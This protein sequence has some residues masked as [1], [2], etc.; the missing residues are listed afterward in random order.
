MSNA[1][2]KRPVHIEWSIVFNYIKVIVEF[3]KWPMTV[4]VVVL[5]VT[6][7][8]DVNLQKSINA[9]MILNYI[10]VL[11]WPLLALFIALKFVPHIPDLIKNLRKLSAANISA[12]FQPPN[13]DVSGSNIQELRESNESREPATQT[14]DKVD[15][16]THAALTSE[17]AKLAYQHIY[18]TIFGTQLILL[19]RLANNVP[20]G[21]DQNQL[22]DIYL[23]HTQSTDTP[24]PTF[25][26]FI[27]YL[28]DNILLLLDSNDGRYKLTYAGAYF[29]NYLADNDLYDKFRQF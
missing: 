5:I 12:E 16:E 27:Q 10:D 6:S 25:I 22:Y 11:I 21:L 24:Y 20:T 7:R 3:I 13:Q 15:K 9:Q 8:V 19:K 1:D 18:E 29:L 23:A 28:L 26:S 17:A 4:I 2:K 14:E